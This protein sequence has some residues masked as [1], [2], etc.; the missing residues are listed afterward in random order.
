MVHC[1]TRN[2][3]SF[4]EGVVNEDQ[5]DSFN[6]PMYSMSPQELEAAVKQNGCFS[7]E[8]MANL[9]QPLVDDTRSVPQLLASTLRSGL[10]GMVKKHFGEEILDVLFDLY[11]KKCEQEVLNF[12]AVLGHNFLF[13][14][15]RKAE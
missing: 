2:L 4:V 5:V 12:L 10:E 8:M 7:I 13:V 6:M 11:R 15:R 1:L 9:T 14:L 3:L